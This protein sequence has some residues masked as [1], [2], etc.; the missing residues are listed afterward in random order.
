MDRV[1]KLHV[2]WRLLMPLL[3]PAGSHD[4]ASDTVD[5]HVFL[6]NFQIQYGPVTEGDYGE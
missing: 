1:T 2:Q 3:L 4:A 5:Y 6:N